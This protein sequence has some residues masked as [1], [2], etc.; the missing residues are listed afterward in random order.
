MP[1]C[2]VT[3][4]VRAISF[5]E[6][7]G[8]LERAAAQHVAGL[9]E[10]GLEVRLITPIGLPDGLPRAVSYVS[11]PWPRR[12]PSRGPLFSIAYWAWCRRLARELHRTESPLVHFHGASAGALR[13]WQPPP[14]TA[15]VVN[16]HG[17]EEFAKCS[18]FRRLGRAPLRHLSRGA[19]RAD[20]VISTDDSLTP[21]VVRNLGVQP[22]KVVVIPNA[23][24][25][26]RLAALSLGAPLPDHF[27]IVTVGRLVLN[28]GYDLLLEAL[29]DATV[30]RVL[31]HGWRWD[32]YGSGP[33][34]PDL[35]QRAAEEPVVPLKMHT[36]QPDLV[37]QQALASCDLF[38]QPSRYEGSSL[39]T[40]EAMAHGRLVVGTPVGGIP[41][42]IVDGRTG[43]LASAATAP[44]ISEAIER[45]L[46]ADREAISSAACALV[47]ER[48]SQA[49]SVGAHLAL[50]DKM[51]VNGNPQ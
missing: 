50:Y 19:Q 7:T 16:P 27:R 22:E 8:G 31:P 48:F 49:A 41:D 10:A 14:A 28:K 46:R 29:K 20:A 44:G 4:C 23:V 42:K 13:W 6:G 34:F 45:A 15:V 33:L 43:I 3:V 36:A 40:L 35:Q 51:R 39:T 2:D 26:E 47:Y 25:V 1:S 30:R 5:G 11:L 12:S 9:I 18:P 17:M 21:A 24:D 37:V 32:H 38:I